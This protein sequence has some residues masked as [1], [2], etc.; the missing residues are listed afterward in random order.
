MSD[1]TSYA[2]AVFMGFFAI[3]NP[4]ANT[5]IF[6]SITDGQTMEERKQTA[7]TATLVAF[8]VTFVFVILGKYIFVLFDISMSAFKITGG[9]LIF[10]IGFEMLMSKKSAT[11]S[12]NTS[13]D[14]NVTISPLAVPILAGPG[15]IVTAMNYAANQSFL[16]IGIV[17]LMLALIIYLNYLAFALSNTIVKRLGKSLISVLGKLMGLILAII[18]AGMTITGIKIAFHLA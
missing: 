17:V 11:R 7:R 5:P 2:L 6:L 3:L 1:L 16:H 10:Y 15:L 18:G 8:L 4:I 14:D 12:T 13:A 9:I